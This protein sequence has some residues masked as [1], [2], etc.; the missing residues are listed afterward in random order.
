VDIAVNKTKSS[1][2]NVLVRERG[3]DRDKQIY[4]QLGETFMK[5]TKGKGNGVTER[6][7][8]SA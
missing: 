3:E 7:R 5:K 8:A 1:G 4:L 6:R 2:T